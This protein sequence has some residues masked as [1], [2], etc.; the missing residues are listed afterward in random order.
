MSNTYVSPSDTTNLYS[1]E[2]SCPSCVAKIEKQL[3][4]LDGV[5]TAKVHFGSGRIEVSHDPDRAPVESL[6]GAV[7]KAG[8]AAAP[9]GF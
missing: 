2:L 9:R 3:L 4:A 1:S 7:R 6:V 8:Y 5:D